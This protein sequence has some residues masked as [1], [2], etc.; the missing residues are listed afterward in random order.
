M[1][2]EPPCSTQVVLWG[3]V[4]AFY[5]VE[6]QKKSGFCKKTFAY[7]AKFRQI[8]GRLGGEMA[9]WSIAHAWKA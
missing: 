4:R 5:F 1:G 7:W 3:G 9:E 2:C 6:T 8:T